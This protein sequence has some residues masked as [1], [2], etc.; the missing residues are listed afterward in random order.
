MYTTVAPPFGAA[1]SP[2][3]ASQRRKRTSFYLLSPSVAVLLLWM[4]VP[5][6]MTLWFSFQHY[7]L[8]NPAVGG[9]AGL[10]N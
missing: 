4:I 10:D 9:F 1:E 2:V 3:E 7:N 8:L 5:L 6:A